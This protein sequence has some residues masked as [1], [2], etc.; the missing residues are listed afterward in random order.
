MLPKFQLEERKKKKKHNYK[1]KFSHIQSLSTFC[2]NITNNNVL[3][4]F[5]LEIM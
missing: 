4:I 1:G 5:L 3:R 2:R